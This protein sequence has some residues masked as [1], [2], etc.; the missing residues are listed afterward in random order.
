MLRKLNI[1][2]DRQTDLTVREDKAIYTY[3]KKDQ[4]YRTLVLT[5]Q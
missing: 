4:E 5:I 2:E 1:N 3:P